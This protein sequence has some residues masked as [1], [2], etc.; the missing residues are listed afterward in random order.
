MQPANDI[1]SGIKMRWLGRELIAIYSAF[2]LSLSTWKSIHRSYRSVTWCND[3]HSFQVIH[4]K[5]S[6]FAYYAGSAQWTLEIVNIPNPTRTDIKVRLVQEPQLHICWRWLWSSCRWRLRRILHNCRGRRRIFPRLIQKELSRNCEFICKMKYSSIDE[7]IHFIHG[8]FVSIS[9]IQRDLVTI[10]W[11]LWTIWEPCSQTS[12]RTELKLSPCNFSIIKSAFKLFSFRKNLDWNALYSDNNNV[13]K[14]N[15]VN[16]KL[17]SFLSSLL[18]QNV[19]QKFDSQNK[20]YENS[21]EM[22][23]DYFWA[24]IWIFSLSFQH[25][26]T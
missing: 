1:N 2:M 13:L 8:P 20:V 23:S 3:L 10:S 21:K 26:S 22:L 11:R 14:E 6:L 5:R 19:M 24:K 17:F 25:A 15:V 18:E 9:R 12:K 7:W 4:C 16:S